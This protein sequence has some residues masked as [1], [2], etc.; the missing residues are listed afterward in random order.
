MGLV[1]FALKYRITFYVMAVLIMLAGG[2]AAVVMP[3][4][5]L[6]DVN[7]P[8]VTIIW[9]YTGL[10]TPDMQ[11]QVTSYNELALSNNVVGIRDME[12][13]TLQGITITRVYFQPGV[14]IGL[15]LSQVSSATNAIRGQLPPG[16][17]PPIVIRFSASSVPVIQIAATSEVESQADVYNYVRF[18]LRST[19]QTTPGSTMP[20]PYGGVPEQV[21][22]DL[23]PHAMQAYG[24]TPMQVVTAVNAQSLTLP[25]GLAKLGQ[26]QFI[27]RLNTLPKVLDALNT[28]PI[29]LV[30]GSP[31]LLRDV[32]WARAGGPPQQN[33]V[34]V[35]GQNGLLLPVLKNGPTSTIEIVDAVKSML[36]GIIAAAPKDIHIVSLF[37]QSVFVSEAISDVAEEGLIAAAL[38]GL[39]ILLFLGSWRATLVVLVSIPLAVLS[40]L[41]VLAVLG[42]T[43]NVMTLGGLALA[44]GILVDDATVAIENT[45][46]VM[47]SGKGFRESV[48]EGAAAIAKPTLISTLSICSAFV[49]VLF[50]VGAPKYIFTPQ[51]LAVVFAMLASYVLSRTLVPILIDVLVAPEHKRREE[52]KQKK[53]QDKGKPGLFTRIHTGFERGFGRFHTGYI[54]LLHVVLKRRL[55]T[56]AVVG[57]MLVVCGCLFPFLGKDYFPAIESGQITLH[58]R[59]RSGTRIEEA[60]KLFS[61]VEDTMREV[62]GHDSKGASNV[63]TVLDNIGLPSVNYNLAFNDGTFVSYSDGQILA[64]LKPGVSGSR[65]TKQLRV[66]LHQRFPDTIFYFQPAD[67]I[68]QILDFGV[69]SQIDVQVH[70]RHG[71][72]DLAM[73]RTLER[74]LKALPGLVDVH[75]QQVV[76][77][78]EFLAEIDRQR[79]SEL[80]LTEQQVANQLNISLSGSFQVSPNFWTDPK[81][82]IPWQLT[83]QTPE[84]RLDNLAQIANTPLVTGDGGVNGLQPVS[85]LSN[86]ATFHRGTEQSVLSHVNTEPTFDVY[87]AVQ[88]M[89]L[90]SAASAINRVVKEEQKHLQAP[91][92][93]VVR[94]QIESMNSAF[95]HI[96]IG[97]VVAVVAVYLLMVLNY[98]DWGDPFVVLCALPLVFCG[99][100]LS[101]FITHT[102]FSIASLMGAIM[103]VGVASANS[104]LLVT[105]AREHRQE[106]GCSAIEGAIAAGDARLRPVLMTAGAMVV[107]L[108]PM[109]L[110]LGQGGEQNAALARAVIGGITVGTCST[111][112]F[113]PFLY[114]LLRK[115]PVHG[116]EDYV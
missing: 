101:L 44:V 7:I 12:S 115:G 33:M 67:I 79:A 78:P 31:I 13:T 6:P 104:I 9:T 17:Q 18:R 92:K 91:D 43:M 19:L 57:V 109:A 27:M 34:H 26:T 3:K 114:S 56:G 95:S 5:V 8:V 73:A 20:P 48:V 47:E 51:A 108:I 75:L 23:D 28:I 40:S 116:P 14:D 41:A 77:A 38:T 2:G 37:D 102:T 113:V 74:R 59:A 42:E 21:M 110:D 68:T 88:D 70:G 86:V 24:L 25:S 32:G 66:L 1:K 90:G 93:I 85:L 72:V 89:D 29:K 16:I 49:S 50:L 81:T 53:E 62:A 46:R 105:F 15:A 39:M 64:T 22:I 82:G 45:Y 60:A 112:L 103:S 96:E 87:A 111:L 69:P 99:I 100:V 80:G 11:N 97:L 83:V 94:G 58:V 30:N 98:Q 76:D 55:L 10:D 61:R 36:P 35:N 54:G 65:V 52:Q 63:V 4:D 107:G 84:Y 71:A 106:T